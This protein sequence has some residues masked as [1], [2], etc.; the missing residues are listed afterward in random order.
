MIGYV[1][2]LNGERTQAFEIIQ[3]IECESYNSGTYYNVLLAR[4]YLALGRKGVA[5]DHLEKAF[6]NHEID[7]IGLYYD[8]RWKSVREESRFRNLLLRIGLPVA[9]PH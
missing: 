1:N 6:E 4:I 8:P 2:A 9:G 7:L 5:Y 3:N